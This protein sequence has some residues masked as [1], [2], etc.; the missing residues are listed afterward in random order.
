MDKVKLSSVYGDILNSEKEPKLY[1]YL[2]DIQRWSSYPIVYQD[3]ASHDFVIKSGGTK[4]A[5]YF[6]MVRIRKRINFILDYFFEEEI[7]K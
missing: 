2:K 7:E 3:I 4:Q 5:V 1:D 6:N